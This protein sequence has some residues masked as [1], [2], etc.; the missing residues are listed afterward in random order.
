LSLGLYVPLKMKEKY[1]NLA[2]KFNLDYPTI[3]LTVVENYLMNVVEEFQN[4]VLIIPSTDNH[5]F[6]QQQFTFFLKKK[7]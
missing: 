5:S 6:Q 4:R 2:L 7:K 1:K 3:A